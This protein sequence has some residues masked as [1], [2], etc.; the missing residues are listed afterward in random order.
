MRVGR[1]SLDKTAS[2][3]VD[4]WFVKPADPESGSWQLYVRTCYVLLGKYLASY[5]KDNNG[6]IGHRNLVI[7]FIDPFRTKD[8]LRKAQLITR[9]FTAMVEQELWKSQNTHFIMQCIPVDY[10]SDKHRN[11]LEM[12]HV[13]RS[14]SFSVYNQATVHIKPKPFSICLTGLGPLGKDVVLDGGEQ[15]LANIAP[16]HYLNT[17]AVV[18]GEAGTALRQDTLLCAYTLSHDNNWI[19]VALTDGCGHITDTAIYAVEGPT[20]PGSVPAPVLARIWTFCLGVVDLYKCQWHVIISKMGVM[21][22][23]EDSCE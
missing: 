7:Y 9:C 8:S 16:T 12:S 5:L 4:E 3:P 14:L 17:P 20:R 15:R 21:S 18:L 19:I 23:F 1:K 13:L 22:D 6:T 11:S 10:V 2:D